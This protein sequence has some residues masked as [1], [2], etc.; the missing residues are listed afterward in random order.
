[1]SSAR[2][3]AED[4]TEFERRVLDALRWLSDDA[5]PAT[6]GWGVERMHELGSSAIPV[7]IDALPDYAAAYALRLLGGT[8]LY[9]LLGLSRATDAT[10]EDQQN[11]LFALVD[12]ARVE[13][14]ARAFYEIRRLES[15]GL[16]EEVRAWAQYAM[17]RFGRPLRKHMERLSKTVDE[18]ATKNPKRMYGT[19]SKL[20]QAS[21]RDPSVVPVL[22]MLLER[23][24][25]DRLTGGIAMVMHMIG[26]PAV[27]PT[28]EALNAGVP[29][30]AWPLVS[31]DSTE[32]HAAVRK[33]AESHRDEGIRAEAE[34]SLEMLRIS[35]SMD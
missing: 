1:M 28:I 27:Q 31:I 4:R 13:A 16:T 7:L 35:D 9:A 14:D 18:L 5:P 12:F 24:P 23:A 20:A 8:A 2:D 29:G 15:E 22:S 30:L 6:Q 11:A 25:D 10:L 34:R 17:D 3:G 33:A 26:E 32:A 21:K 19:A